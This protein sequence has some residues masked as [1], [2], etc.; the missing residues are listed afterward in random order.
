[1]KAL[2]DPT[3]TGILY[4]SGW[5]AATPPA[6]GYEGIVS[7][8]PNSC[9]VA[10]VLPDE[11]VFPIAEPFFWVACPDNCSADTWYYDT[12]AQIC[13]PIV[14]APQP[15]ETQPITDGTMNA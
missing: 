14:N 6:T 11:Q 1:M 10:E 9:R 12:V 7:T 2:I 15:L 13:N 3:T 8:Y 4:I 5:R